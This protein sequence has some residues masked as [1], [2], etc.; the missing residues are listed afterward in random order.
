MPL[1]FKDTPMNILQAKAFTVRH[2][3]ENIILCG[4]CF[5]KLRNYGILDVKEERWAGKWPALPCLACS[6]S[7]YSTMLVS[8]RFVPSDA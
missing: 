7:S 4:H 1:T 8:T 5:V 2:Q 3:D 6:G